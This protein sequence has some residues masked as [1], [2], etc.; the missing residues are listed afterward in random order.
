MAFGIK[1]AELQVWKESVY[2]GNISFLTHYW[3][4]ARFPQY[5]TVTKVGC[6]N[7]KKLVAWGAKYGLKAQW[8]HNRD[9][10]PHFDLL[11]EKQLKILTAEEK[12]DQITRFQ[13][14]VRLVDA[15]KGRY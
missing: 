2:A 1:R 3:Y 12:F 15:L 13:L 11:G 9:H 8:I 5:K 14:E 7:E 4:D 6:A 10:F